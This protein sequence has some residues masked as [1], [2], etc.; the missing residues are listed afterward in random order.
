MTA[1]NVCSVCVVRHGRENLEDWKAVREVC[2]DITEVLPA[3]GQV[4]V[5]PAV[6]VSA[7]DAGTEKPAG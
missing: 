2:L 7:G 4:P 1:K 6:H 5:V 3:V